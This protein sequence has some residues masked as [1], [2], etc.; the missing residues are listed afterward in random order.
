[1]KHFDNHNVMKIMVLGEFLL[2]INKQETTDPMDIPQARILSTQTNKRPY[3]HN[4]TIKSAKVLGRSTTKEEKAST[5]YP[6]PHF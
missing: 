4:H 2:L 3:L 5:G 6:S 1:M